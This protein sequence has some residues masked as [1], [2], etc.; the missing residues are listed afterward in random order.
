MLHTAAV[1]TFAAEE[2]TTNE[3]FMKTEAKMRRD[4]KK[5]ILAPAKWADVKVSQYSAG[6]LAS[7]IRNVS[8]Q[9]RNQQQKIQDAVQRQEFLEADAAVTNVEELSSSGKAL[10][11]E[12][13]AL[14]RQQQMR[15]LLM[16]QCR[17]WGQQTRAL[18]ADL[19]KETE[20]YIKE[21]VHVRWSQVTRRVLMFVPCPAS[22]VFLAWLINGYFNH[23][24]DG[25]RKR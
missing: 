17:R 10:R 19:E 1:T 5:F 14:Q 9:M 23:A 3:L 2:T 16:A 13:N 12:L 11:Q 8:Q 24:D 22:S 15:V 21:M 7:R 20:K 25:G 18:E 6:E 4:Y